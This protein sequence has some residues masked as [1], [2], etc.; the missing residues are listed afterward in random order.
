MISIQT[1]DLNWRRQ[2]A[3]LKLMFPHLDSGDFYYDYGMKDVMM[4][5]LQAKLGKSR[6]ELNILLKQL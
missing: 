2:K 3:K 1:P 6:E 4:T 5:N